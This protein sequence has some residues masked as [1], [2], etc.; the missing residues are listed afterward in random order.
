MFEKETVI[1]TIPCLHCREDFPI[2]KKD[3][4]FLDAMTPLFNGKKFPF[5]NPS[6][7][8]KCRRQKRLAWRNESKLYRRTCD[9]TRV[10][11]LS[12]YDETVKH[13][14]YEWRAWFG[15]WWNPLDYGRDFDFSRPFFEQFLE[16]KNKVPHF[17]RSI[18][19]PENSEFSNNASD[20][21][22]CYLCFNGGN[23]EDCYYCTMFY[24]IK[25]SSDCYNLNGSSECYECVDSFNCQKVFY[26][27]N[28]K[29]S[30]GSSFL[31]NCI[32]CKNCFLCKNLLNGE[33]QILNIQYSKE[34]YD[35][36]KRE[37]L[38]KY[39]IDQLEAIFLE[40]SQKLPEKYMHWVQNQNVLGEYINNSKDVFYGFEVVES[41]NIRYSTN[42]KAGSKNIMDVDIFGW[43][44]ENCYEGC[45]IGQDS[46][47][48]FFSF[49]CWDHI[50][51]IFYCSTCTTNTK[52]C[53]GCVWLKGQEYCIFN[54]Q[55]TKEEYE[56]QVVKIIEHMQKTGEW[57]QF[58]PRYMSSYGYNQTVCQ[59][60]YPLTKEEAFKQ[61]F[62]WSDVIIPFPKVEKIIPA[63]KLPNNIADIPDDILN[64]AI[65]CE[66]TKRPFKIIK[67]ELEFYRKHTLPI[68]HKHPEQRH[69]ERLKKRNTGH[70]LYHL[71]CQKCGTAFE[72]GF[73]PEEKM[74]VY[75]ESCYNMEV[76]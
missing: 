32:G 6:E 55:Y 48:I 44:L 62:H 33:F 1:E 19:R 40:F 70:K 72:S 34:E 66:V 28:C 10:S 30:Y 9:L 3:R 42:I 59:E 15:D 47:R 71:H 12:F 75:C 76:Y 65:E 36:K 31:K 16:L 14:V 46:S 67:Q 68:P 57:G 74:I 11:M 24:N 60:Y 49:D 56:Q 22:N 7:C 13:P 26:S 53:F 20:I 21:K 43:T 27:Q 50:D 51:N 58:F 8:Q 73:N 45:V 64:W 37:Y 29:D 54:K 63:S 23:A 2:Y 39:T 52:N 17:S 18:L 61:G 5:P 41:E 35:V 25:D 4:E 69:L 38:A